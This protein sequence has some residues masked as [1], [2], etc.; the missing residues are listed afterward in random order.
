VI[1]YDTSF[2]PKKHLLNTKTNENI[3]TIR[4]VTKNTLEHAINYQILQNQE[5]NFS[6]SN[7]SLF[8]MKRILT[9]GLWK[10]NQFVEAGCELSRFDIQGTCDKVFQWINEGMIRNLSFGM[11]SAVEKVW[12]KIISSEQHVSF[13]RRLIGTGNNNNKERKDLKDVASAKAEKRVSEVNDEGSLKRRKV[14]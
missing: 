2:N 3:P 1:A 10:K 12:G 6:F 14:S 11:E 7:L 8:E 13:D 4:L 5:D 9:F